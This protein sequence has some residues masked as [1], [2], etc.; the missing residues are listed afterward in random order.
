[1]TVKQLIDSDDPESR[2]WCMYASVLCV[3]MCMYVIINIICAYVSWEQ[4]C[5]KKKHDLLTQTSNI[6]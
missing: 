4:V 6:I 2:V 1:M 5:N 3:C